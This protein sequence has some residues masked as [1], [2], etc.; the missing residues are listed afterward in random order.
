MLLTITFAAR[1]YNRWDG[2]QPLFYAMNHRCIKVSYI[3][4]SIDTHLTIVSF[5]VIGMANGR[6][7]ILGCSEEKKIQPFKRQTKIAADDIL[8]FFFYLSK[9]IRLDFSCEPFV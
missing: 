9:K 5:T 1:A 6:I 3:I 4:I 8:I 7:C 2:S